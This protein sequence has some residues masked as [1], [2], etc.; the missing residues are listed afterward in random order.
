MALFDFRKRNKP[1]ESQVG[2][3]SAITLD[4]PGILAG[5]GYHMLSEAPEVASAIWVI[6]DLISSMPIHLMENRT[7]GDIRI[8][9]ALS[10]KIDI[11]PWSLGTRQ[12]WIHWIVETMLTK[13][14]AV[15]IPLTAGPLISDLIPAPDAS[16][17]RPAGSASCG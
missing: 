10:R 1:A 14:E 4:W 5:Q 11:D 8:N 16:L 7:N 15:V 2:A 6:A 17:H 3:V 12:I 13:G 9:D